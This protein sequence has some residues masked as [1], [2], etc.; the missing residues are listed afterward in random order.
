MN[1]AVMA[2]E[3]LLRRV[4]A[5][6]VRRGVLPEDLMNQIVEI[7]LAHLSTSQTGAVGGEWNPEHRETVP[8]PVASAADMS[9]LAGAKTQIETAAANEGG[10]ARTGADL[11][12]QWEREGALLSAEGAPDAPALVRQIREQNQRRFL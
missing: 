3:D 5:E 8:M 4:T 11:L 10:A 7:G 12:A 2:G 1:N 6:A 9:N